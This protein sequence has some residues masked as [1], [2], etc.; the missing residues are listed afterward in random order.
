MKQYIVFLTLVLV[1]CA[2][3]ADTGT[4]D[5]GVRVFTV[6][7]VGPLTGDGAV[8]GLPV[9]RVTERAAADLNAKWAEKNMRI[10]FRYEDGVCSGKDALVAAQ[11]L[12]NIDGVKVIYG[13]LCS[14]ETLGI[15]PF[16]E[17]NKILLFSALSS[18]PDV[19][20]AGDYVFRNYPSD[21]AQVSTMVQF[22]LDKGYKRVSILSEN[23]DYAQALRR[24]YQEQ[25]PAA[26][27]EILADETVPPQARDVRTE[28]TKVLAS[29]PDAVLFLPQ[30]IPMAGIFAKQAFEL[31]MKAQGLSN[32]VFILNDVLSKHADEIEGFYGAESV[33]KPSETFE[34]VMKE[35]ECDLS[36]YCATSYDAVFLI[37]DALEACGEDT[38]CMRDFFY[39]TKDWPGM[40]GPTTFDENGDVGGTFG[41]FQVQ[42]GKKV[43]VA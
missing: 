11:K 20:R 27:I 2:A 13:G 4:G 21:T 1:A 12:V 19:T 24:G 5:T 32:E 23:T 33:F 7:W 15:A 26:G 8:Y 14:G 9:Q 43:R 18:S 17:Q 37:G 31:G 36:L 40:A 3:P 10:E 38:D 22:M 25:L 30:T 34:Q 28:M 6:G 41:I 39:S 16:T 29:D 35:T 42:D